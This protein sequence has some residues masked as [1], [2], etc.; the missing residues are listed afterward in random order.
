MWLPYLEQR[1]VWTERRRKKK[2]SAVLVSRH[3][4]ED[5]VRVLREASLC[6]VISLW[7]SERGKGR[8]VRKTRFA[9]HS[10]C[11]CARACEHIRVPSPM[12]LGLRTEEVVQ[13][14]DVP[15]ASRAFCLTSNETVNSSPIRVECI[16]RRLTKRSRVLCETWI[17]DVEKSHRWSN[18]SNFPSVGI[19]HATTILRYFPGYFH[20]R[21]RG[22]LFA[23]RVPNHYFVWSIATSRE[24]SR[25]KRPFVFYFLCRGSLPFAVARAPQSVL[26]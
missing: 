4:F 21:A 3:V 6:H 9:R 7:R 26:S 15:T 5:E 19:N 10:S 13:A 2:D 14:Q 1:G 23:S 24:C 18:P 17:F 22:G 12:H 16:A 11:V 8:G 20:K 25:R